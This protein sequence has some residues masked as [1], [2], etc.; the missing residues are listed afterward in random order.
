MYKN[1]TFWTKKKKHWGKLKEIQINEKIYT[2]HS[3]EDLRP[4]VSVP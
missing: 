3:T 1:Y 2:V 4:I